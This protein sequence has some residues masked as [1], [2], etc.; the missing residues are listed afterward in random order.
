MNQPDN[1]EAGLRSITLPILASDIETGLPALFRLWSDDRLAPVVAPR[2][3]VQRLV[4]VVNRATPTEL[5]RIAEIH[6]GFPRLAAIFTGLA[7][8]NAGLT[9]DRDLYVRD[10]GGG[11]EPLAARRVRISCSR[12]R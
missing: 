2:P 1:K 9:G 12:P 4:V 11:R 7:V 6:A 5:A 8:V 3:P 10:A